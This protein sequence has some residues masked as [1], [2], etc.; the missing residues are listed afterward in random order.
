[1]FTPP[2]GAV[3]EYDSVA[4]ITLVEEDG[5]IKVREFKEVAD[6]EKRARFFKVLGKEDQIT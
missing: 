4:I 2:D 5:E 6:A 1:M 3:V